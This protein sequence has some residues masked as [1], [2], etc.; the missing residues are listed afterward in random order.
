MKSRIVK[1]K[2]EQ[3]DEKLK[4]T[5][6]MHDHTP[7][8]SGKPELIGNNYLHAGQFI[9]KRLNPIFP[10]DTLDLLFEK[11]LNSKSSQFAYIEELNEKTFYLRIPSF[12]IE[13]KYIIDKMLTDYKEEILK[14]DNLIIDLRDNGGG[15]SV[16]YKELIPLLYT[17][18][19]RVTNVEYLSSKLNNQTFL[20]Y[21]YAIRHHCGL[22]FDIKSR[23]W[24]QIVYDKLIR[25]KNG[26]FV[27]LS[28]ETF[29]IIR[30][31]TIYEYPKNVGIIINEGCASTTEG[32]LF[33][34]KQSNKVKLFGA[35][36]YGAF[37][38]SAVNCVE[39]P[40]KEFRLWYCMSRN[41]C[42]SE[43]AIDDIGMQPD[44]YFDETIPQYKWV[45]YVNEILNQ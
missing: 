44:Y 2:I 30:Q 31:D 38:T 42:I 11:Y 18:S 33:I 37:D 5:F 22:Y 12:E 3:Y 34:A 40:C 36:T 14:T 15:S 45:E 35:P 16:S 28:D 10:K 6:Y 21:S 43:F 24:A 19:I 29:H 32:L 41:L 39:S 27:A 23:E 8:E 26:R 9:L 7:V 13:Y 4:T 17:D 20:E 1:L 25:S